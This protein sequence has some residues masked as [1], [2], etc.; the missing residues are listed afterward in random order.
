M[1]TIPKSSLQMVDHVTLAFLI[2]DCHDTVKS[3]KFV[4]KGS[5]LESESRSSIRE[6]AG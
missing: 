1:L 2:S 4:K 5:N 6:F 3:Y